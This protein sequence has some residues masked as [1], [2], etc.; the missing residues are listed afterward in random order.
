[1]GI[2]E[3]DGKEIGGRRNENS[4]MEVRSYEAG[5]DKKLKH[6]GY[7]ESGGNRKESPRKEVEVVWACDEKIGALGRK[8]GNRNEST[9]EKEERKT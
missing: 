8:E 2:E 1:M 4:T 9:G 7:K 5:Q 3:D 6:N